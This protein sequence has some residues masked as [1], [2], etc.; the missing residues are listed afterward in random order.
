[1]YRK[2]RTVMCYPDEDECMI[3]DAS[4]CVQQ[5]VELLLRSKHTGDAAT[6][7]MAH[8]ALAYAEGAVQ[9]QKQSEVMCACLRAV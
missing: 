6:T 7:A 8:K 9:R 4:A 5:L 1:M 2:A 3:D